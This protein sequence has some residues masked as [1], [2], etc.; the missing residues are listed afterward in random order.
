MSASRWEQTCRRR[1]PGRA[2]KASPSTAGTSPVAGVSDELAR[3]RQ[4]LPWVRIDK[5][6]RF[7]TDDGSASLADLFQGRSQLLVYHFMFGSD[8]EAGSCPARRSR[9]TSTARSST[10]R[11]TTSHSAWCRGLRSRSCRRTSSG[12]AGASPGRPR[13]TATSTTTSELAHTKEDWESGA[14]AYLYPSRR[15]RRPAHRQAVGPGP[16]GP[17]PLP[18]PRRLWRGDGRPAARR[19]RSK[20][21]TVRRRTVLPGPGRGHRRRGTPRSSV[22]RGV[23]R[24]D[25]VDPGR[26]LAASPDWAVGAATVLGHLWLQSTWDVIGRGHWPSAWMTSRAAAVPEYCCCPVTS[27]PSRTAYGRNRP[28]TMKLVPSSLRA[29]SSMRNGWIRFPT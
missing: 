3:Q 20:P 17:V 14:I 24:V 15:L 28:A 23:Q 10:S 9:T 22:D 12:W 21:A 19:G 29:S 25:E 13:A 7:E 4:E 16:A 27:S 6:Y 18:L 26:I 11:T 1:T 5:E 8:Y 2:H